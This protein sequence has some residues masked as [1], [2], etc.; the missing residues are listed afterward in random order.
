[1]GEQ[2]QKAREL[3][4]FMKAIICQEKKNHVSM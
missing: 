3:Q 1:M 2:V 4:L